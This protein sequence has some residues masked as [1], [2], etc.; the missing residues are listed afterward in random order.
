MKNNYKKV[1]KSQSVR[2]KILKILS[3]LPDPLILKLQYKIKNGERLDLRNPTKFTE[4]IQWY[5]IYHRD[6]LMTECSDKYAVRDYLNRK[7]LGKH[8]TRLLWV[9]NNPQEINFEDLPSKFVI[10]TTNGSG[11]NI[12]VNDK[13]KLDKSEAVIKLNDWLKR[14]IYSL[15]REWSYKNIQ[16]KIII[17]EF[18]EDHGNQFEG[19]SDYKFLCFNG[20]IE[21]IV[22]D[23]DRHVKHKRNLYDSNWNYIKLDTDHS[24]LGDIVPKPKRLE[25][26]KEIAKKLAEDFPF[27]R[28]DL[29]LIG[30]KIYFGELTFY[31]WSGYVWFNPS[32]Y[33]EIIG[34]KWK[35]GKQ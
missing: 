26:M 2:M 13:K 4:K 1:F 11:T 12:L 3:I 8:L 15:G 22:L 33:D 28:V 31:P 9:G 30:D 29:Y 27:V 21:Y 16:P 34:G 10:K 5:K 35:I 32:E 25:E 6:P 23:V 7:G 14:D 17:E 20:E 24:T 18:L 19:I